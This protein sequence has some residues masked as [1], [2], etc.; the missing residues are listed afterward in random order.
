MSSPGA[1]AFPPPPPYDPYASSPPVLPPRPAEFGSRLVARLLDAVFA[2]LIM[3]LVNFVIIGVGAA[4]DG[5]ESD[6]WGVALAINM[7]VLPLTYEWLQLALW[8]T[9]LGKRVLGLTV[10]RT[11][12]SPLSWPVAAARALL[13]APYVSFMLLLLPLPV[14]NLGF[15]LADSPRRR[16]L[17]SRATETI[18]MDT[19]PRFGYPPMSP[20]VSGAGE[21]QEPGR[22]NG[23]QDAV[24]VVRD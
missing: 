10:L 17:H 19:R 20:A 7:I 21:R 12:G 3:A 16:G 18:V 5:A 6:A 4:V 13:N 15:M 22:G 9:T 2:G 23:D 1:P 8:G 11:D 24:V 14:L